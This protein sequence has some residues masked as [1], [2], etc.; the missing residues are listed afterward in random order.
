[1]FVPKMMSASAPMAATADEASESGLPAFTTFQATE[2]ENG[3]DYYDRSMSSQ[4]NSDI[5]SQ[6]NN[7]NR[8]WEAESREQAQQQQQQQ[9]AQQHH[10]GF[11]PFSKL[12]SFQSQFHSFADNQIT[13]EP[14]L[15]TQI[16]AVPV[17]ISPSSASPSGG[18]LTQLTQL[19]SSSL[20]PLQSALAPIHGT[21]FH[22]LT[23]VNVQPPRGYPLVP[24]P[25]QARDLSTVQQQYIDERHIQ[26]YQP[27]SATTFHHPAANQQHGIITVLKNDHYEMKQQ[28]VHS[29]YHSNNTTTILADNNGFANPST[30]IKTES[31]SELRESMTPI[32]ETKKR[33]E[34]RK[35][36]AGSLESSTESD[37]SSAMEIDNNNSGNPGQVAAVS[38]TEHF[39]SPAASKAENGDHTSTTSEKQVS[40]VSYKG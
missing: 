40:R 23:A 30:I 14:S 38:S 33:G 31:K 4:N 5:S 12:P 22:T 21:N 29:P 17:P 19:T 24:A 35:I 7:Y 10:R 32:K 16:T 25:I 18:S 26:L 36:R 3:W 1:M 34:K 27:I 28:V 8:P 6:P 2:L 39:K 11:E 15:P 20:T 13:A 9:A 37:A